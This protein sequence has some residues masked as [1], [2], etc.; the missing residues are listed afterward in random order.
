M[1]DDND[2]QAAIVAK[3]KANAPLIAF[4]TQF[5]T[6][7]EIR[8]AAW[9]GREFLYPAVRV[10]VTQN[11]PIGNTPCYSQATITIYYYSE[12]D[13]SKQVNQLAGLGNDTL[14]EKQ[15]DGTGWYSG[16]IQLDNRIGG[17]RQSERVWQATELYRANIFGGFRP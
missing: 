16:I 4:L 11:R 13:S 10:E 6:Q 14:F 12:Y 9:Q 2:I 7:A 1:I 15:L 8:E 17:R 3:L 5:S